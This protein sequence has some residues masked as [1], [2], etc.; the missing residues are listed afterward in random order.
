[1]KDNTMKR[2]VAKK[3][4]EFMKATRAFLSTKAGFS[5]GKTVPAEWE[6]SLI[7]LETYFAEFYELTLK[8]EEMDS[9]I[10]ESRYGPRPAQILTIRDK[11]A[12]RLEALMKELGLGLKSAIRMNVIEP[13]KKVSAV[14]KFIKNKMEKNGED[15]E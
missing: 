12:I 3:T 1:M 14:E 5:D 13:K 7:M 11:A 9:L 4:N 10:E 15:E 2:K 8:I 6:I